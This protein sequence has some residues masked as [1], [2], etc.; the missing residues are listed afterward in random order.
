MSYG[1]GVKF[2]YWPNQNFLNFFLR[3]T[4]KNAKNCFYI[5]KSNNF[6]DIH[7]CCGLAHSSFRS[8]CSKFFKT[9]VEVS[10]IFKNMGHSPVRSWMIQN[11][12]TQKSCF[13]TTFLEKIIVLTH[14]DP[15]Y[16]PPMIYI[17]GKLW[18]SVI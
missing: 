13:L 16:P 11:R 17:V 7:N 15:I 3:G 8:L 18:I 5:V 6:A 14:F 10:D 4:Q 12:D 2:Q 1:Q 9:P